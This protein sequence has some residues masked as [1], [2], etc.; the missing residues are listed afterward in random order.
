MDE[1]WKILL[2]SSAKTFTSLIANNETIANK[3]FRIPKFDCIL[4]FWKRGYNSNCIQSYDTVKIE[5]LLS[6]YTQLFPNNPFNNAIR[7]NKLYTDEIDINLK[8]ETMQI[9][10]FYI[11][12]DHALR[13][14]NWGDKVVVGL[15]NRYGYIGDGLLGVVSK[16]YLMNILPDFEMK[17]FYGSHVKI[18]GVLHHCPIEHINCIK[19]IANKANLNLDFSKM[20]S[21]PYI[22]IK[23]IKTFNS[24]KDKTTSLLGTQWAVTNNPDEPFVVQY[25]Q[26]DN[27]IEI[28]NCINNLLKNNNIELFFDEYEDN[29]KSSFSQLFMN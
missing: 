11:G 15:Y 20:S 13:I 17:N 26:F 9:L 23:K 5:C 8:N 16:R 12:S 14:K 18:T 19:D 4:D 24:S 22:E 21:I 6:P 2:K 28:N 10:S 7:W 1:L 29:Y 25:G 27:P 3:F